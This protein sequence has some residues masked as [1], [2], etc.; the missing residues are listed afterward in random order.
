MHTLTSYVKYVHPFEVEGY[1]EV[2]RA[3]RMIGKDC[4][5][6]RIRMIENS[7]QV[8]N[9]ILTQILQLACKHYRDC[10]SC[11]LINWLNAMMID[12]LV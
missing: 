4:I 11:M 2:M 3:L 5:K 6:K 12:D 8:P 7:E 9:D 10:E 1:R